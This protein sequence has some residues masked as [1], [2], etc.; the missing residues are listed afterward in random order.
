MVPW[1]VLELESHT[2]VENEIKNPNRYRKGDIQIFDRFGN[3]VARVQPKE[4]W[5]GR[6][7]QGKPML[8]SVYWFKAVA[9][10]RE[11]I[12]GYFALKR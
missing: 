9:L 4:G 11:L 5:D 8:P 7:S 10:T 12:H 3:L 2:V 6:N 1:V